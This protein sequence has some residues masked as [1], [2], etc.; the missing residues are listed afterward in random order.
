LEICSIGASGVSARDFFSRLAKNEVTSIVDTRVHASSQLAG[1]TRK[2]SLS[3]FADTI[4]NIKYIHELQ[5]APEASMLKAYRNK[6]VTWSQYQDEYLDLLREREVPRSID[7]QAWG[8]RPVLLCSE[9]DAEFCH[10]RLAA[11]FID[12]ALGSQITQIRH[13]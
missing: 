13:L 2:D 5:L 12:K 11:E 6:T 4:L 9:S 7:L 10:R 3:Y 1:F 8:Q